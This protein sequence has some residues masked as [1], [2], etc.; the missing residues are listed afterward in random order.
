MFLI[1]VNPILIDYFPKFK[2]YEVQTK[3]WEVLFQRKNL[4]IFWKDHTRQDISK[5][6]IYKV[7]LYML[8]SAYFEGENNIQSSNSNA[9]YKYS[10]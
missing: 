5:K 4:Y 3:T 10:K 2:F 8:T 1:H 9:I 6:V 7:V